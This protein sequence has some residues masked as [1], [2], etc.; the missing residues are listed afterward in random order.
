VKTPKTFDFL[1][2]KPKLFITLSILFLYVSNL[3]AQYSTFQKPVNIQK[4]T[5]PTD[6]MASARVDTSEL[7]YYSFEEGRVVPY[8]HKYVSTEDSK[9]STIYVCEGNNVVLTAPDNGVDAIYLWKG[10]QGFYSMSQQV[11]VEK[12]NPFQAGYYNITIKKNGVTTLGRVKVMVKEK[13]MAIASGGVYCHGEQIKLAAADAGLGAKYRWS[14]QHSNFSANSQE[15]FIENLEVGSHLYNLTV[16]KGGCKSVDTTRVEVKNTPFAIVS[17]QTIKEGEIAKLTAIDAGKDAQYNWKGPYL[18]MTTE[19]NP[20]V[21]NL[22]AGKYV[23]I[24]TVVK[25]GCHSMNVAVVEVEKN[26][27]KASSK[28]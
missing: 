18:P 25:D 13:P 26:E 6:L 8:Y 12:I 10:P 1:R 15:A 27:M 3:Y 21:K 2:K 11:T 7:F 17:N 19:Q 28:N 14:R 22:P 20:V 5:K 16:T 23:Y 4:I 24:L 9:T